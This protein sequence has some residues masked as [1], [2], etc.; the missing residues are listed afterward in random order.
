MYFIFNIFKLLNIY[1]SAISFPFVLFSFVGC[2]SLCMLH[3]L[4]VLYPHVYVADMMFTDEIVFNYLTRDRMMNYHMLDMDENG[5]FYVLVNWK[6]NL[7]GM[8]VKSVRT[9]IFS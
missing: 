1:V 2:C 9:K 7:D 8:S 3:L 5:T 4:H 6:Y